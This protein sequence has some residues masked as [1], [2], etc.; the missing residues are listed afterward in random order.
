MHSLLAWQSREGTV[1]VL[2]GCLM[3]THMHLILE[4]LDGRLNVAMQRVEDTYAR[5][6]NRTRERTGH[7]FKGRYFARE[8]LDPI[9]LVMTI[10]YIDWNPV[11][12]QMCARPEEYPHGTARHYMGMVGL[13][14]L[15]K[16]RLETLA[17]KLAGVSRYAPELYPSIWQAAER[18]GAR[19]LVVRTAGRPSVRIAPIVKLATL[20]PQ[21]MQD[22]LR[23][24]MR[25]E[26]G[27]DTPCLLLPAIVV[28]D[29]VR[30]LG[31]PEGE[32]L[33]MQAGLLRAVAG[34]NT[35]E[36]GYALGVSQAA[37]SRRAVAHAVRTEQDAKYSLRVAGV[38]AGLVAERYGALARCVG[39]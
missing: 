15:A 10:D 28:V 19:P 18:A 5:H 13:S 24:Q 3:G 9:D 39:E 29:C 25:L 33:T 8:I 4:S 23:E 21:Y 34:L 26:E 36:V 27:R 16:D 7:V 37:A 35:V 12:A 22:W 17:C 30:A 6:Y 2:A 14:W 1:Q 11:S 20:G 31:L 38:V 32:S